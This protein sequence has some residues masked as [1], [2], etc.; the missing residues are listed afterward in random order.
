MRTNFLP[1]LLA[2]FLGILF[3]ACGGGSSGGPTTQGFSNL[4]VLV[5]DA[6][7]S[8]LLAFQTTIEELHLVLQAG[9]ESANLLAGPVPLELLSLQGSAA[10]LASQDLPAGTYRGVHLVFQ[11]GSYLART[12]D[13]SE[14]AVSATSDDLSIDFSTPLSIDDSSYRRVRIDVDLANALSGSISTPPLTFAPQGFVSDDSGHTE[15]SIDEI[16][17][18]VQSFDA[19]QGSL[20]LSAFVDDDASVALGDVQVEV[21]PGTLLVQDG[22]APFAS[23]ADFF[24][25]LV[26]GST[27][28]EVHGSLLSGAVQ[29]T[30]IEVDD[31]AGGGGSSNL[32][33]LKGLVLQNGPGSTFQVSIISVPQG[34]A[35]VAAAFGGS[36][37]ATLD[38]SYDGSTNWYLHEHHST[39]SS[40]LALGQKVDVKF[41]TFSNAPYLASRV[42][43]DDESAENEGTVV[44]ASG[45]PGALVLHLDESSPSILSGQVDST[46]I[47]VDVALAGATITL[48]TQS[49]PTLGAA[50]ILSG[51]RLRAHGALSGPSSAPSIAATEI[52][53][54][55]G[56]LK[57][58]IVGNVTGGG[59]PSF[60]TSAGA[61]DD[62]FGD[63]VSEGPLTIRIATGC[64]FQGEASTLAAFLALAAN[65][66]G[67][68]AVQV[69]VRGIGTGTAQEIRAYLI[70]SELDL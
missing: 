10:W 21:G 13:G 39:D 41:A 23:A 25:A 34:S 32:V 11:P 14:V 36:V 16:K 54:R 35:L 40:A 69:S 24:A 62:P 49:H 57:N 61:I 56:K 46:S 48:D 68:A 60:T 64:V 51:L 26:A 30:R 42:E 58:A 63:G 66:P 55:A 28:L 6:P 31:N 4:D 37:P 3:P 2:S 8:E 27:R 59:T 38:V 45:L 22:G 9:G 15:S 52:E 5:T 19:P 53:V 44:D 1:T 12:N 20:V 67:G 29:A 70:E 17:G 47:D 50:Q 18:I 65:P 33:R 43:I 7:A